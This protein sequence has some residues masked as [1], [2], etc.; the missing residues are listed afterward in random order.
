VTTTTTTSGS[1]RGA[2]TYVIKY[3]ATFVWTA[4]TNTTVT[5]YFTTVNL[6]P[7]GTSSWS[8][9]PGPITSVVLVR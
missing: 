5:G 6:P 9:L 8:N 7:A 1:G 2:A 3:I 4:R